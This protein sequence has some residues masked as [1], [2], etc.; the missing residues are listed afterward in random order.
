MADWIL[1]VNNLTKIYTK[2][3]S[4]VKNITFKVKKNQIHAFIGENG[5]GKTTVIK[6]IVD[7]YQKFSGTILINNFSNKLPE[8]KKFIG[9]VPE[10]S[11]FPREFNSYE[12]LYEFGLLSKMKPEIVK[13][14]IDYYFK[15]LKIENLAKLKPFNFSSGQKRK[16]M[17]IQSLIHDPELIIFDEPFS[18]LDPSARNEFLAIIKILQKQGK[19][20]FLSSHNL[21]EIDSL[22]DS[23]TLINKGKIYYSGEKTESLQK[24]YQK[25]I[26]NRETVH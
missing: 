15:F 1:V 21:Q 8:A 16:I 7:A 14:K 25:Y 10:N 17:I 23:L 11:F 12:F 5:A 3:E 22:I 20:I 4:G 9:Y 13:K 24:M 19:T 18:N 2:S 26:Q 6:C